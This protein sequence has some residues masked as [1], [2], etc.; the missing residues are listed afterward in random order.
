MEKRSACRHLKPWENRVT[1]LY[2]RPL[3]FLQMRAPDPLLTFA[4]SPVERQ[5]TKYSGRS[6]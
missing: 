4:L 1:P 2:Q 3:P 5:V 6:K